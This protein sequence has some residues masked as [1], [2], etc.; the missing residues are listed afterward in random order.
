MIAIS[1]I[2]TH[3][4]GPEGPV[5]AV[6]SRRHHGLV[7]GLALWLGLALLLAPAALHAAKLERDITDI[8]LF[9]KGERIELEFSQPYEGIPVQRH[10]EGGFSL[11]FSGVGSAKP[12][13]ELRPVNSSLYSEVK[14]VQNRYSTTISFTMQDKAASM[15]DR[16]S[17]Q[18]RG[19]VFEVRVNEAGSVAA[20]TPPSAAETAEKNLLREMGERIAGQQASQ[21]TG[22]AEAQAGQA[23]PANAGAQAAQTL[24]PQP[25]EPLA[26]GDAMAPDFM[27]SMVVMVVALV[28]IIAMLYGVLF[29]YNRFFNSRLRRFAGGQAIRQVASFH[30]GPRQRILVLEINGEMIAC[31][32]TPHQITYITHL[33]DNPEQAVSLA[34]AGIAGAGGAGGRR[35]KPS[36]AGKPARKNG[37]EGAPK[38]AN[39]NAKAARSARVADPVEEFAENLKQK[40]RSLKRIN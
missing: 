19:E 28:V 39:G 8:R 23:P 25:Q 37:A 4:R 27:R 14:V 34:Q 40:V 7:P 38:A 30:V 18:H 24:A 13:R 29:V 2:V 6:Q 22:G 5:K 31:G 1:P 32:V 11:D 12:V 10:R 17:F 36:P 21:P 15:K 35:G 33:G 3:N 20:S 16:L 26:R 9:G